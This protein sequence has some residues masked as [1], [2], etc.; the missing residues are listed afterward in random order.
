MSEVDFFKKMLV[1]ISEVARR[2]IMVNHFT[3]S[4]H[5]V[6]LWGSPAGATCS[7]NVSEQITNIVKMYKGRVNIYPYKGWG[8]PWMQG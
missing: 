6:L 1:F 2:G 7:S 4:F 3:V 8:G 5:C